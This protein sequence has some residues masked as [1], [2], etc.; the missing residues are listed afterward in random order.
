[1][2]LVVNFLN[3]LLICTCISGHAISIDENSVIAFDSRKN[4][5]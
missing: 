4:A 5:K 1:M 3:I 2:V